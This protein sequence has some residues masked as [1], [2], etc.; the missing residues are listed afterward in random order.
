MFKYLK[1]INPNYSISVPYIKHND[2]F[3]LSGV[4]NSPT[5]FCK[6]NE[7]FATYISDRF[8]F[9]NPDYE[10]N[11]KEIEYLIVGDSFV[12]GQCVNRPYDIASQL[13]KLTKKTV[14]S[15]GVGERGPLGSYATVREYQPSKFKNLIL[16]FTEHNDFDDLQNE[17]KNT[18]LK[19]YY[20]LNFSQNLKGNQKLVDDNIKIYIKNIEN[21]KIFGFMS[22]YNHK[23]ILN[24]LRLSKTRYLLRVFYSKINNNNEKKEKEFLQIIKI[25]HEFALKNNAKFYIVFLPDYRNKTITNY[26]LSNKNIVIKVAK[27]KNIK[28]I[29]LHKLLFEQEKNLES[30]YPPTYPGHFSHYGYK[31]IAEVI[32]KNLK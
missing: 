14:I 22:E 17:N 25:F 8:G 16:F 12:E 20:D 24:F 31:K 21:K 26:Q 5:L 4:S 1:E 7:Y 11:K 23:E 3:S 30:L 9:N 27:Q 32:Y 13:R 28:L 18:F 29:D 19:K 2:F 6:E 15:L 10:W